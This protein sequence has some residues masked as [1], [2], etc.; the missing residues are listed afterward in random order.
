MSAK[1]MSAAVEKFLGV[2]QG[3]KAILFIYEFTKISCFGQSK[4][5]RGV[6]FYTSSVWFNPML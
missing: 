4:N 6:G 2:R 1:V 3:V 5:L